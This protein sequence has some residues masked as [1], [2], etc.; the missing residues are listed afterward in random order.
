MAKRKTKARTYPAMNDIRWLIDVGNEL[1]E[2][3]HDEMNNDPYT[4]RAIQ[5]WD[6]VVLACEEHLKQPHPPRPGRAGQKGPQVKRRENEFVT[7]FERNQRNKLRDSLAA[8]ALN[9]MLSSAPMCDRT[10]VD[11]PKWCRIAYDWADQM[12]KSRG[13]PR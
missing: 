12:L 2:A 9:G 3:A 10:K 7:A 13:A 6:E 4:K 8:A 1:A 5:N 11:K